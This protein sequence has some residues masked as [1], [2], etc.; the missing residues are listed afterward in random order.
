M[1][2]KQTKPDPARS[3]YIPT[4]KERAAVQK[5]CDRDAATGPTPRFKARDNKVSIDHPDHVLGNLLTLSALGTAN[6]D[7][8]NGFLELLAN[9]QSPGSEESGLNFSMSVVTGIEPRDQIEA[10]I[11]VQMAVTQTAAMKA[12]GRL[13]RAETL[14]ELE[15]AERMFNKLVRTFT[16]L[17]E[18]LK[19]HRTIGEQNITIQN[20]SVRDQAQAIVGNINQV[21]RETPTDA[22]PI[23]PPAITD[24]RVAPMEI[25]DEQQLEPVPLSRKSSQ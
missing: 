17:T 25:L 3:D 20:V 22:A 10:M 8:Q 19:R 1:S 24:A 15:S 14:L 11:G 9:A 12:A 16:T 6:L 4:P 5:V 13:A 21:P 23:S 7:F 2:K 18:A